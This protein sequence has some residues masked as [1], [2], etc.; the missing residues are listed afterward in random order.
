M[1]TPYTT[2]ISLV[3]I[4]HQ[5]C[6]SDFIDKRWIDVLK[7]TVHP[8]AALDWRNTAFSQFQFLSD[9]CKLANETVKD[10]ID[11][12]MMQFFI[13]SNLPTETEFST[14]FNEILKQFSQSTKFYFSRL[15]AVERLLENVDQ[16]YMKSS[17]HLVQSFHPNLVAHVVSNKTNR[18]NSLNFVFRF[19]QNNDTNSTFTDCVCIVNP[20]CQRPAPIYNYDYDSNKN[21]TYTISYMLPG[22]KQ[23]C[24]PMDSFMLSNF[25][26]L[27]SVDCLLR[28]L[29]HVKTLFILTYTLITRVSWYEPRPLV[30]NSTVDRFYPDMLI[31]DIIADIMIERW[32]SSTSYKKFYENCAPTHCTYTKRVHIKNFFDAIITLISMISGVIV[33]VRLATPLFIKLILYLWKRIVKKRSEEQNHTQQELDVIQLKFFDKLKRIIWKLLTT[34]INTIFSLNLFHV[35]DF[36]SNITRESAQGL[37]RWSTRLYIGLFILIN[38]IFILHNVIE[39]ETTTNSYDQ[40]SISEY[41]H[42]VEIHGEKLQCSCSNIASKYETFIQIQPKHYEICTSPFVSDQWQMNVTRKLI[43]DLFTYEKNDYRVFLLAHLKFLQGLC[44]NSMEVVKN[45]IDQFN[46]T[47]LITKKLLAKKEFDES[48]N[49][50]VEQTKSN[51]PIEFINLFSLLLIVYHGNAFISKYQSNYKYVFPWDHFNK[52]YA[53]TEP[54]IYDNNC[55][56]GLTSNCTTQAGFFNQTNSMDFIPVQGLKTGCL[57]SESFRLSTLECF[58]N[59]SCLNLIQQYTNS[60][61]IISS[62][63][64][65]TNESLINKTV[66]ELMNDLFVESWL[67]NIDYLSYFNQCLPSFCSYTYNQRYNLLDLITFLLGFQAGLG[68]VLNWICPR[69]VQVIVKVYQYRKK[70]SNIIHSQSIEKNNPTTEQTSTI[71]TNDKRNSIQ[72]SY[73]FINVCFIFVFLT[74]SLIHFTIFITSKASSSNVTVDKNMMITKRTSTTTKTETITSTEGA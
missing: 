62:L 18:T 36:S 31:R 25:E 53:P 24:S 7:E 51:V 35:R 46:S 63:S 57:P 71:E 33:S 11:Q 74:I 50:I 40:P 17:N 29:R 13:S 60:T 4:F 54:M 30:Y 3:P 58:Y 39:S 37:G 64:F 69:T 73:R 52:V 5:V 45:V 14:Q 23:S 47:L 43:S 22:W 32:N 48:I 42:L 20:H 65:S 8:Y 15:I 68:I 9:L 12:F 70:R 61:G 28:L 66:N 44:R 19:M 1:V 49:H 55:T 34:S 26:C 59:Q 2:I 6:Q 16:P 27:Y 41:H 21:S 72:Y 67:I 56:C 10:A 38:F